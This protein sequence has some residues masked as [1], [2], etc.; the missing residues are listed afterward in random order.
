MQAEPCWH[1]S[2]PAE[3]HPQRIAAG[4]AFVQDLCIQLAFLLA[5]HWPAIGCHWLSVAWDDEHAKLGRLP[6]L[7]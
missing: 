3:H 4:L 2:V 1:G 7:E 6:N 5:S